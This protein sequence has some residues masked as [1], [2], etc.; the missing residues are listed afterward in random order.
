MNRAEQLIAEG[1]RRVSRKYGTVSRLDRP[2]WYEYLLEKYPNWQNMPRYQVADY[3]L[4]VCS[5][6]TIDLGRYWG[7]KVP[8][9]GDLMTEYVPK[10]VS[11]SI[12]EQEEEV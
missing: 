9:V 6:D 3:Y 11:K 12:Q 1:Y 10:K 2:D 8:N 7:D 4:R 5:K